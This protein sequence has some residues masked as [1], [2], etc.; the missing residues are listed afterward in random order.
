[1]SYFIDKN[2]KQYGHVN[3]DWAARYQ[4]DRIL[5]PNNMICP[6]RN[7][8]DPLGRSADHYS[9]NTTSAGCNSALD[10]VNIEDSQRP[11]HFSSA[12]LSSLGIEGGYECNSVNQINSEISKQFQMANGLIPDNRAYYNQK[13]REQQWIDLGNKVQYYKYLSGNSSLY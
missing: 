12:S 5:N 3:T 2:L 8:I 10:R 9:L 6:I 11:S 1:M 7:Y 13:L 4:T